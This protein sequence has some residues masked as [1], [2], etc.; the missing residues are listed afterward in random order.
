MLLFGHC[1]LK[2][3]P[4]GFLA[5]LGTNAVVRVIEQ[6]TEVHFACLFS[7]GFTT[8]AVSVSIVLQIGFFNISSSI[9]FG[10]FKIKLTV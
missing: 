4:F 8:I 10:G 1:E 5:D 7:G 3:K 2:S 6:C 9:T